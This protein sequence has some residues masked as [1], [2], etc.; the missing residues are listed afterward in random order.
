MKET[1]FRERLFFE[2]MIAII[3]D[4]KKQYKRYN[5]NEN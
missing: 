4:K 5:A 3:K 2:E 1:C